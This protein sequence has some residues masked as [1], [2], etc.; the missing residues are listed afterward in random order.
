MMT[1]SKKRIRLIFTLGGNNAQGSQQTFG[2][3]GAN[4][5]SV[6]GLRTSC[7]IIKSG[8]P[9]MNECQLRV[10]GL[11]PTVYNS[12]TSIYNVTQGITQNTVEVQAGDD[13]GLASVFIGQI[14]VAQIDPNQQPDS[15]L[16]VV[17]QS[18]YLQNLI[19]VKATSYPGLFDVATAFQSLA[20]LMGMDF[21]N[22]GV[23]QTLAGM[24]LH[25]TAREQA[26][27]LAE[28]AR[29]NLAF[30][31]KTLVI[32]P[33]NG[34]RALAP[35]GVSAATGMIGYPAYS[36]HGISVRTLFNPNLRWGGQIN[37]KSSLNVAH[38]NGTWT[39]CELAHTLEAEMPDGQWQS[40]IQAYN[41][42]AIA[43]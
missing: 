12:L 15:V 38:L 30:D 10:F 5:V 21:E 41:F 34:S 24:T 37:L 22:N 6:E 29:I 23:R 3:T 33:G 36:T 28:A 9:A 11:T 43:P 27:Q 32:F 2:N 20:T 40:D 7:K 8:S 35:V 19:P 16:N 4:Q 14:N 1:F 31:D 17:A 25:G 13:N 42:Q 26:L 39:V 18:A